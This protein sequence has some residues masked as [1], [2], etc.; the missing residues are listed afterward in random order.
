[1]RRP[2]A[3]G[4]AIRA[5]ASSADTPTS[6]FP[7]ANASPCIVAIPMRSPVNDPGPIATANT[8]TSPSVETG[9]LEE[10][11]QIE[12][13][14]RGGR[15]RRVARLFQHDDAIDGERTAA[16]RVV[17]SRARMTMDG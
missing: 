3:S 4:S 14:P 5:S 10:G 2:A 17:V 16:R 13:Q 11:H 9:V 15:K 1:M 8:S 7:A 12:R 6:G